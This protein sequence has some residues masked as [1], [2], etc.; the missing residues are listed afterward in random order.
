MG[1]HCQV[2]PRWVF[3]SLKGKIGCQK[4]LVGVWT[5][6]CGYLLTDHED[7]ICV[8]LGVIKSNLPLATHQLDIKNGFFNNVLNEEIYMKKPLGFVAQE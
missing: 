3:G 8:D 7:D 4:L 2:K 6:L 5:G 1:L